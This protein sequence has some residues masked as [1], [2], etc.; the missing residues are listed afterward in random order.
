MPK[1]KVLPVV[2]A[3][4]VALF[5]GCQLITVG[6]MTVAAAVG[7]TGYAVYKTGDAA[8]TGIGKATQAT[9][10]AF[11]SGTQSATT[12]MFSD[13][14][15]KTDYAQNVMTVWGSSSRA[16]QKAQFENVQGTFNEGSGK[17]TARTVNNTEIVIKL[18]SL[19]PQSTEVRIRIGSPGDL[20]RAEV[21]HEMVLRELPATVLPQ[22]ASTP[23]VEVK[24]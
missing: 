14:E 21:I 20:K 2:L 8:I 17:L 11:S 22:P 3:V 1:L 18:K 5:T 23:A 12:V 19:G 6:V 10:D 24:L 16:L 15:F 4:A 9:G 13:G 7:L